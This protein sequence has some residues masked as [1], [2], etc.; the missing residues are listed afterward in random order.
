MR[1]DPPES[2]EEL[3]DRARGLSGKRLSE[4]A[5]GCGVP[6][7][8]S[9]VHSKGWTGTLLEAALGA[10]AASLSEPDFQ[11]IGV[12]LKSVPVNMQ[13]RPRE[14][15]HVCAAPPLWEQSNVWRKL[16]RVL[17]IPVV[18]ESKT[19]FTHRRIGAPLLWSPSIEEESALRADWGE[20][21]DMVCLGRVDDITARHGTFLQIRP[22]AANAAA[23]QR[24]VGPSGA[25]AQTLPRGFYLRTV[26]TSAVF[27]RYY[28][29]TT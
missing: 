8:N 28:A 13:G 17:W 23:R 16:A 1:V 2:E 22:K 14:S 26:F 20:L 3:F 15:T 9:P 21:M 24:S 10:T 12:E 18:C 27:A 4:I 5:R 19:H 25:P 6:V 7:P 11:A 29:R